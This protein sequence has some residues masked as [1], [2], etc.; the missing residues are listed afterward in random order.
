[1]PSGH[2][3]VDLPSEE[4]RFR[5]GALTFSGNGATLTSDD[6]LEIE[7]KPGGVRRVTVQLTHTSAEGAKPIFHLRIHYEIYPDQPVI[8]KWLTIQNLTDSAFFLE[9]IEIE[10]LSFF[11]ERTDSLQI[12]G[13]DLKEMKPAPWKDGSAEAFVIIHASDIEGGVVLGNESAGILKYY[14][15][16]SARNTVSIGLSP[17][18][19]PNGTEMRVPP[20]ATVDSPHV[21]TLLFQGNPQTG[22]SET[23]RL[24]WGESS[25]TPPPM[26]MTQINPEWRVPPQGLQRDMIVVV[27]YDWNIEMLEALK[28]MSEQVH[29]AGR[30]LGIRLPIAE[31]NTAILER[32]AWQLTPTPV[33]RPMSGLRGD[34]DGEIERQVEGCKDGRMEE[35]R[36]DLLTYASRN[37]RI[38]ELANQ[39]ITFHVSR[40]TLRPD[41]IGRQAYH[42]SQSNGNGVIYCVLSDY[43]YYLTQAVNGLLKETKADMLIFDRPIIGS[44]DS[45][46]K[47]CSAFGHEHYSRAESIG[48]LYRWIFE[49]ADYLHREYPELQLGI[50]PTAYGV[51][52]PDAACFAHFDLFFNERK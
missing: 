40:F 38:G 10:S 46:L 42:V 19:D 18:T 28:R 12:G 27:D 47:G 15:V 25:P 39:R 48:T 41:R 36:T 34:E 14:Q 13:S 45:P 32:P 30:K 35:S 22:F 50:T 16:Y 17:T 21:W 5:I 6:H 43:G 2:N 20:K 49:F 3:Y 51:E 52:R 4:F 33:L 7:Q 9:D 24:L 23:T 26:L 44:E 31:I 8:R 29:A 37:Q 11:A 1:K